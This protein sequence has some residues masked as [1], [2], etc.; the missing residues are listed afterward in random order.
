MKSPEITSELQSK[1]TNVKLQLIIICPTF[2]ELLE[3]HPEVYST[4]GRLFNPD[5]VI[6]MLLG[7]TDESLT[8]VHHSV[9]ANY[10]QWQ[11]HVAG[12][13]QDENFVRNFLAAAFNIQAKVAKMEQMEIIEARTS[14][15]VMPRKVKK[16]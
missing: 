4:L 14:F 15:S 1:I 6:A 13:D 11:R 10:S 5:R 16:V 8:E 2:L 12:E 7:V 9:L 3:E